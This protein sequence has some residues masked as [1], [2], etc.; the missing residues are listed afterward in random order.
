LATRPVGGPTSVPMK[1]LFAS[2]KAA[3]SMEALTCCLSESLKRRVRRQPGASVV[4]FDADPDLAVAVGAE[5]AARLHTDIGVRGLLPSSVDTSNTSI[6]AALLKRSSVLGPLDRPPILSI[7]LASCAN[8]TGDSL[9]SDL[10]KSRRAMTS[11][12]GRCGSEENL[13]VGLEAGPT[14][15]TDIV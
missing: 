14:M 10:L 5:L 11:S 15:E 13:E 2:D 6:P 7:S 9:A 12:S 8:C 3:E 4:P 1:W